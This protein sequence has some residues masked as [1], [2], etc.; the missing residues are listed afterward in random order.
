M[1]GVFESSVIAH[2]QSAANQRKIMTQRQQRKWE[3]QGICG[4]FEPMAHYLTTG[5]LTVSP[6]IFTLGQPPITP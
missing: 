4:N 6:P 2:L 5:N 3:L 1:Q